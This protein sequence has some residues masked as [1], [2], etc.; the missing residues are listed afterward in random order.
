MCNRLV[1]PSARNLPRHGGHLDRT[2]YAQ[3]SQEAIPHPQ[4]GRIQH[5]NDVAIE[6]VTRWVLL[7]LK[8]ESRARAM[9]H[10]SLCEGS[11]RFLQ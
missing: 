1:A 10:F 4:R 3:G 2:Y 8:P 9:V 6:L 5:P 11:N 7:G